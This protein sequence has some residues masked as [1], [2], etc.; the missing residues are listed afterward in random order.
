[1]KWWIV[2][3]AAQIVFLGFVLAASAGCASRDESLGIQQ[4][5]NTLYER[6]QM[7][8]RRL[9]GF[10]GQVKKGGDLY[11]RLEE[12]QVR[13][14]ALN[15]RIEE[16][17]HKLEQLQRV[18]TAAPAPAPSRASA[19]QQAVSG[20][21]SVFITPSPA[22]PP[23]APGRQ[24]AVKPA[25]AT[26]QPA[27]PAAEPSAPPAKLPPAAK[28]N[29]PPQETKEVSEKA[30]YDKAV[31]AYQKGQYGQ[32][33]KELQAFVSR[34]PKSPHADSALFTAG[35]CYLA[36]KKYQDAV[37]MYQMVLDKYP[38]GSKV[39]DALLKQGNAFQQMGDNTAARILYERLAEKFPGSIQSQVADKKLKQMK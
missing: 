13:M 10:D 6:Q 21:E 34:Y 37:E 15:G 25:P 29:P 31:Q 26:P 8:E 27:E 14:G 36:E 20:E 33:R 22:A 30:V 18:V 32:A 16:L 4:S 3:P 39:P 11:A 2:K 9:E 28:Q 1:M 5:I 23:P 19:P 38:K 17:D 24:P 12:M 7:L 35:E